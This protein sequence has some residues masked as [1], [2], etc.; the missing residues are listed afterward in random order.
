MTLATDAAAT[1]DVVLLHASH[2]RIEGPL[3]PASSCLSE[4]TRLLGRCAGVQ[5]QQVVAAAGVQPQSHVV[6]STVLSGL[7]PQSV[8][9]DTLLDGMQAA[10]IERPAALLRAYECSG[11]GY[12]LRFHALHTATRRLLVSIVDADLHRSSMFDPAGPWGRSGFGVTALLFELPGQPLRNLAIGRSDRRPGT[13]GS[14]TRSFANLVHAVRQRR[15]RA[16]LSMIF[17][18]FMVRHI[19]GALEHVVGTER[20]S[21]NRFDS[22]GHCFGADPWIG[23]IEWQRTR[24]LPGPAVV[25]AASLSN[26]GYYTLC[27]VALTSRTQTELRCLP[28]DGLEQALAAIGPASPVPPTVPTAPRPRL[29]THP[30]RDHMETA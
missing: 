20:I 27:D 18:H 9:S 17:V 16:D 1:Q 22:Y 7:C 23:I 6:C 28:G 3:A 24:C 25:T 14:D 12:A 8:C 29:S 21:P 2:W 15:A 26:N 10:G 19:R 4:A 5:A 11:W 30:P 13:W